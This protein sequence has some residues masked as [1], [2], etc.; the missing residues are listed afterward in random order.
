MGLWLFSVVSWAAD[1]SPAW[2]HP[3]AAP[4][5]QGDAELSLDG[6]VVLPV[7]Y[8]GAS[9]LFAPADRVGVRGQGLATTC[10]DCEG[11][12]HRFQLGVSWELTP[13]D[14]FNVAPTL[15][16]S[17]GTPVADMQPDLVDLYG[18]DVQ[19]QAP[20]EWV[21][22]PGLALE[23]G[24]RRLRYDLSLGLPLWLM[25]PSEDAEWQELLLVWGGEAGLTAR[26]GDG[27][28]HSLRLATTSILPSLSYRYEGGPLFV[29]TGFVLAGWR[30]QVGVRPWKK[31]DSEG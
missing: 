27:D 7:S 2:L 31:Q 10:G 24:S 26:L 20:A 13:G 17:G 28:H 3:S 4:L 1:P 22:M 14:T 15:Q 19:L 21:L 23:G 29:E 30:A 9:V 6:Q 5:K 12:G 25:R 11:P 8:G 16:V 18:S